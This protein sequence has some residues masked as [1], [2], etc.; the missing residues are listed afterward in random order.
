MGKT[1]IDVRSTYAAVAAMISM[2]FALVRAA[3]VA[4]HIKQ[5]A[6][7]RPSLINSSWMKYRP[8]IDKMGSR[9][10]AT[11]AAPRAKFRIFPSE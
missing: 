7:T 2:F 5:K 10:E 8:T 1:L 3:I 4:E 6:T 9:D 11:T